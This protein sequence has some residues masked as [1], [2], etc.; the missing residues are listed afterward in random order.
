M[1]SVIVVHPD[2]DAVWPFAADHFH[3]LWQAQGAV[4]FIRLEYEDRRPLSEVIPHLEAVTRLV[5]LNVP[6][7]DGLVVRWGSRRVARLRVR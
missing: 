2:F 6:V 5:V 4:E 7:T 3:A 1:C